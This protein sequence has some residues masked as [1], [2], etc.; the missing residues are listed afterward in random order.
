[1]ST[2]HSVLL[3][4]ICTFMLI[5]TN[6]RHFTLCVVFFFVIVVSQSRQYAFKHGYYQLCVVDDDDVCV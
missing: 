1:M 3:V 5:G 2:R 6:C 4:F